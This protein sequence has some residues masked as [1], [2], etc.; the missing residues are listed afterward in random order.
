MF[1]V[2]KRI[3]N[4]FGKRLANIFQRL[5]DR[6]AKG[7]EPVEET[8]QNFVMSKEADKMVEKAVSKMIEEQRVSSGGSFTEA[9]RR[10][11]AAR[12][13]VNYTKHEL[14]GPVGQRVAEL[15]QDNASYIKTLPSKWA[16]RASQIAFR[17][18]LEGKRYEDIEAELRKKIPAEMQRNIKTIARTEAAKA[19]AA[20]AQARA[21]DCGIKC[22]IWRTCNDERVRRSHAFMKGTVCFW[23]NPPSPEGGESYNPGGIYNCRCYAE[24]ILDVREL[25]NS[26]SVWVDDGVRRMSKKAFMKMYRMR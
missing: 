21:E 17:M 11:K 4:L 6:V 12:Q 20:I 18:S 2:S 9:A 13:I 14:K 24:P 8:M 3:E 22:Y 23:S 7:K 5:M 26:F 10:A 25:P 16:D 15:V 1:K 19:N